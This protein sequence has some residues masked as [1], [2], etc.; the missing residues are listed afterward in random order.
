[1][2]NNKLVNRA[3]SLLEEVISIP[4]PSTREEA[5]SAFLRE[6]IRSYLKDEGLEGKIIMV[7]VKNNILLYHPSEGKKTLLLCAHIDTVKPSGHPQSPAVWK[8]EKLYGLG[9]NDDGGSVVCM[10]EAFILRAKDKDGCGLLLALTAEE[11][12]GGGGGLSSVLEYIGQ[13]KVIPMPDYALVGEPTGMKAAVGEKGLLILDA[14]VHGTLAHAAYPVQD[15]AVYNAIKDIETL[16][17]FTFRRRSDI[18]GQ[19][20]LSVTQINAGSAH[21]IVPDI[22]TYVVDIRFNE[23]YTPLEILNMLSAKV[24]GELR[25]RNL[26]HKCC[27]TRKGCPLWNTVQE[28]GLEAFVSPTSSDWARLPIPAVK[29]GPGE[30]S[31]SHKSGEYI[32]KSEISSGIKGYSLIIKHLQTKL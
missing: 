24:S 1:M 28:L 30:S 32:T 27:V 19:T 15:N 21:N 4:A 20:H 6:K 5:R 23:K 17:K 8:G 22:C 2:K 26:N 18:V 12:N 14:I 13:Q 16:K 11:E 3:L 10:L 9:T 25:A 31:R 7:S 29:I